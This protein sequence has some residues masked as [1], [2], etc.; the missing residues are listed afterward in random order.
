MPQAD[1]TAATRGT[2]TR[3]RSSWRARS[4][5]CSPAAPPNDSSAKRR[6][7][8]PRRTETSRTPSAMLVLT[9]RWMPSAAATRSTLS[10]DGEPVQRLRR[11]RR[12]ELRAAAEEM[13]RIEIAEHQV[14]VGHG[15]LATAAAVTGGARHGAGAL[16]ADMQDAAGVDPGD[17]AAAGAEAGDVEA[18]QRKA[19][20]ADAAATHQRWLAVD[21]QADIGAGAAHVERDQ[22][23]R[24][25][26]P[27]RVTLPATPPAG[28]D[29]TPPA[30]SRAAS[31]IGA[32]PPCD[33]MI[34][35]GPR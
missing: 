11:R 28:P 29:S 4:V 13:R 12:I 17:R 2:T 26:Q 15:G 8:T 24:A 20:A 16:R 33:W 30:A 19:M 32:T 27:R 34:R 6:G 18:V 25:E 35:V 7:S 3:V 23:V 9:T 21:D 31:A 1:S 14:G 5:T 10:R 22:V